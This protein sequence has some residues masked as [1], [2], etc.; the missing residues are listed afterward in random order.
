MPVDFIARKC[1]GRI[2]KKL[3]GGFWIWDQAKTHH[4]ERVC[5]FFHLLVINNGNK[6]GGR[7]SP[8]PRFFILYHNPI[9]EALHKNQAFLKHWIKKLHSTLSTAFSVSS[10]K[11]ATAKLSVW[12][13]QQHSQRCRDFPPTY[14]LCNTCKHPQ[15]YM[16]NQKKE[17]NMN[18]KNDII[19]GKHLAVLRFFWNAHILHDF[20]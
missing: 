15:V 9:K 7:R 2:K 5:V 18:L 8:C 20:P 12:L 14:L 10:E 17:V 11:A 16:L 19:V 13:N 6:I 4:V 1:F 3:D